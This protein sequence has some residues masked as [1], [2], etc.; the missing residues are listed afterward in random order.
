MKATVG[1]TFRLDHELFEILEQIAPR[2]EKTKY[3][4]TLLRR[5]FRRRGLLPAEPRKATKVKG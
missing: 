4:A 1:F 2:G 5:D 3:L